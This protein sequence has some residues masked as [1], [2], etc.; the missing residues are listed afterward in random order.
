MNSI[1]FQ[2]KLS[3]YA[4]LT[5]SFLNELCVG[6]GGSNVAEAM[7]YSLL[8]GGKRIRA[9]LTL[10]TANLSE[11]NE[12]DALFAASAIEMIHAYSLIH[13]DL[14]CMDNDDMRRGKP[15]CHIKF[16]ESTALLAGDGL[17]TLA[18]ETLSKISE[19]SV[20]NKCVSVLSSAAGYRGMIYG[21]ELDIQAEN[22]SINEQELRLIHKNK[23]GA[24]IEASVFMG[25]IV[26]KL[27]DSEINAL[28]VYAENLGLVF[29]IIDD[30]LDCTSTTEELGKPVGSDGENGKTTYA[31]LYGVEE[32]RQLAQ[33]YNEK[34][35]SCV[36]EAFGSGADF[37]IALAQN[38]LIRSK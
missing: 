19:P 21:Q 16:G 34:A 11:C 17:L 35:I 30:I 12:E 31:S 29:Q 14:P 6:E 5:E 28:R 15:S 37:L 4:A 3:N 7:R 26:A 2:Q 36:N 32:A 18:F 8:G 24:I 20:S 9:A 33:N 22:H 38:L 1:Q 13:D 25:A 10:S 23:T 27:N